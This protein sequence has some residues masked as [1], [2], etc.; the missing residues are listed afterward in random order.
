MNRF[1]L[2]A[3]FLLGLCIP[4]A[5]Q[6]NGCP[7]GF[8]TPSVLAV[9]V[10]PFD[11]LA[12]KPTCAFSTRRLFSAYLGNAINV[13]RS[14]DNTTQDIGFTTAGDLNTTALATFVGANSG[15]IATQYNQGS[16]TCDAA[17]ATAGNQP[18][19]VNAGTN[20][21]LNSHVADLFG[22]SAATCL[23]FTN[24]VAQPT[25]IGILAKLGSQVVG[26]HYTDGFTGAVRNLIGYN[27][28]SYQMFAG[29]TPQLG[30]TVDTSTHSIFGIFNGATSNLFVD[31]ANPINNQNSGTNGMGAQIIGGGDGIAGACTSINGFLPEYLV[32]NSVV[33]SGDRSI[34]RSSWQ[35]YWGAP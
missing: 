34:V 16:G 21:T 7:A 15:F 1:V 20:D 11:G 28:G 18:R 29:G 33:S 17:Q 23:Q 30:G 27:A 13:R 14:S 19:I 31:A 5:A 4:A 2:V 12:V 24:T 25:S 10:G 35:S 32:W 26:S 6:F 9:F 8:C 22:V 3:A